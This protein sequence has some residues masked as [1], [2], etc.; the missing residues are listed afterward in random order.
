MRERG[1][2][3][4]YSIG[5]REAGDSGELREAEESARLIGADHEAILIDGAT[6]RDAF[7]GIVR[8]QEE[9][10]ADP[11][12][13]ALYFLAERARRD[14]RV[15]LSGE[16]ADELFCGYPIYREAA[17]LAP[18]AS[19]PAGLRHGIGALADRLPEGVRG[20]GYL[21]R[22]SLS[23][24]ER[25][26]GSGKAFSEEAKAA[27]MPRRAERGAAR[28]RHRSLTAA[29]YAQ[30][31]GLPPETRQCSTWTS[32]RGFPGTFS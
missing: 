5:F 32:I 30:S 2:V 19:L 23:L 25:F 7:A 26:I 14:V 3:R 15:I 11:A 10:L 1:P 6:Y 24:E 12:A 28:A 8:S 27:L 22:G 20:R 13:P 18:I 21:Q 4:A 16:G 31:R 9:P 17:S 29:Y